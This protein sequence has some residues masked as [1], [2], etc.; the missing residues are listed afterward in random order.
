[1]SVDLGLED[2]EIDLLVEAVRR[3][4][5]R[6]F[7]GYARS[8]LRRRLRAYLAARGLPSP[9]AAIPAILREPE[10]YAQLFRKLSVTVTEPFRDPSYFAVLRERVFPWLATHPHAK[11][12]CAGCATGE[13]ALSLAILLEEAGLGRRT[14]I[15]AT[16]FND[17]ALARGRAGLVPLERMREA[18]RGY[19]EAGGARSLS[20]YYRVEGEEARFD[21]ELVGRVSF[22][23]HDLTQDSSF[24]AMQ[25]VSCR[26]V[27][28]Y[29]ARPLQERVLG[30]LDESLCNGGFLGL[31]TREHLDY[32]FLKAA[33]VEEDAERRLFRKRRREASC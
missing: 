22:A 9:T 6:D 30:L 2:L 19:R 17:E 31:G 20:D 7:S 4:W 15:Y 24:G 8:S 25:L 12:W 10:E 33:Y 23:A 13:E 28:I 16:D 26:N 14:R 5:G 11:V 1:M 32:E 21:P 29:F 3:R 18:S 27:L